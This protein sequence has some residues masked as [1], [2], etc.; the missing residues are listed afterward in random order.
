MRLGVGLRFGVRV[1][2]GLRLGF[3]DRNQAFSS[4]L[5]YP[6]WGSGGSCLF[7]SV[8]SLLLMGPPPPGGGIITNMALCQPP[9]PWGWANRG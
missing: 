5:T 2:L 4:C 3:G 7:L 9:H 1:G 8:G 6:T